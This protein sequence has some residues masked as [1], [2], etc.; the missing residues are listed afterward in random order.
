MLSNRYAALDHAN[1]QRVCCTCKQVNA[2][3]KAM[4]RCANCWNWFHVIVL[5]T[6]TYHGKM[7]LLTFAKNV[8]MSKDGKV[9]VA[10]K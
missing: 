8:K 2:Q 9:I 5:T 6:T 7:D 1:S 4:V 3:M 10:M